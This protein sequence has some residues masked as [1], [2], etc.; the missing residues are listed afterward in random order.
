[1]A[2]FA[3]LDL[4]ARGPCGFG[5]EA[6]WGV[7][8]SAAPWFPCSAGLVGLLEDVLSGSTRAVVTAC[9]G[10]PFFLHGY[11]RCVCR[12][13]QVTLDEFEE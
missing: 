5:C 1:M 10:R 12:E 2:G 4:T 3:A 8:A 11:G 7:G 9:G 13:A 6:V